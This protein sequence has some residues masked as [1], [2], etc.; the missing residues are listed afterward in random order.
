[1]LAPGARTAALLEVNWNHVQ[2]GGQAEITTSS[3]GIT[4]N[5]KVH[6]VVQRSGERSGER[7]ARISRISNLKASVSHAEA[8]RR[9]IHGAKRVLPP[10]PQATVEHVDDASFGVGP[11]LQ[12]VGPLAASVR[13]EGRGLRAGCKQA[14]IELSAG[15][16]GSYRLIFRSIRFFTFHI[17]SPCWSMFWNRTARLQAD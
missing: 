5:I 14:R 1:V 7:S 10:P 12:R 6:A 13:R 3:V 8:V 4:T 9:S 15:K 17:A 16:E 11:G 2:G